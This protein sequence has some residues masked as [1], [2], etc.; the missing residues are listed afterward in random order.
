MVMMNYCIFIIVYSP[1]STLQQK[2]FL[3]RGTYNTTNVV[4][5][6]LYKILH[7]TVSIALGIFKLYDISEAGCASVVPIQLGLLDRDT[8][9]HWTV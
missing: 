1:W 3:E 7:R 4:L 5:V 8:I 9:N 6:S 2:V